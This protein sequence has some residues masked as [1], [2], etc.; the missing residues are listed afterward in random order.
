MSHSKPSGIPCHSIVILG[1][2]PIVLLRVVLKC[3]VKKLVAWQQHCPQSLEHGVWKIASQWSKT[4]LLKQNSEGKLQDIQDIVNGLKCSNRQH[5][6]EE[7]LDM[8]HTQ[9]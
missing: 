5:I 9:V 6:D 4:L 3:F 2:G 8:P 7:V 1:G